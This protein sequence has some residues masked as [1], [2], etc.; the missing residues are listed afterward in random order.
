MDLTQTDDPEL[1]AG[2]QAFLVEAGQVSEEPVRRALSACAQT[3][4]LSSSAAHE[5]S[6]LS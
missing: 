5:H 2:L 6:P 4:G 1:M 3:A